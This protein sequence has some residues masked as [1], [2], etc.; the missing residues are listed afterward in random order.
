MLESTP[1]VESARVNYANAEAWVAYDPQKTTPDQLRK[2]VQQ[3]GY[4]L[5]IS[6]ENAWDEQ[7]AIQATELKAAQ[8]RLIWSA[9]FTLPVF[10]IGMFFMHWEIGPWVSLAF[11]LPI[12][13]YFG[14]HFFTRAWK[15]ARHRQASMD[16]LVAVST[17]IA[18]LFS[19]FNTLFP[20]WWAAQGL[21]AHV[22]YEAVA[23]IITFIL[24]GKW[25][26][27]RAKGS[28]S[29][30]LKGLMDLQPTMVTVVDGEEE[31]TVE[32]S[33]VSVG[34]LIRVKPGQKV[35]VDGVVTEG[36]SYMEESTITGESLPAQKQVG[37]RVFAGTLNQQG[38]LLFRADKVG[39]DTVLSQI[40][41]RVRE[42]QGSQ[43]PVQR[44]VD[45]IASIFVPVVLALAVLTFILWMAFGGEQ[46][47]TYALLNSISVLVIACP[48][49]LGLATPTAI[50][51]GVGKGAA[52]N[53]L[54][55]DAKSLELARQV[56]AVVLDKTGTLTEG[57]PKV[58]ATYPEWTAWG[59]KDQ[60]AVLALEK[61][62]EHPLA[63]A[64]A[65]FAQ[66]ALATQVAEFTNIPGAGVSGKLGKTT[67]RV[68]R[69]DWLESL[70]VKK[71]EN[72]P[73]LMAD[74][75]AEAHTVIGVAKDEE[76]VG[77]LA[78]SD[79]LKPS[80]KDAVKALQ[81]QGR[82]VYLL[83]G[84]QSAAAA[85]VGYAVGISPDRVRARQLPANKSAFVKKL[86]EE[87]NTVAMVGDGVND[88]E[89][90]AVA[91]VSMAMGQGAD[92]AMDVASI[93][94]MTSD[95]RSIA[96]AL[97]LSEKTV[98]GIRQNLFWAF[99]YN[100]VGIPIAAGILYP[101]TGFL[102]NPMIA[103]AAMAFSSV[104]VVLNSLRLRGIK[105]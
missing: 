21:E 36:E 31:R 85:A 2:S 68:G 15:Q 72:M 34:M 78:L 44:L 35:A 55:R 38:S 64:V 63:K 52:N 51:V 19:L 47:F 48:C 16:T 94:L 99:I 86:Q 7:A 10:T 54:I 71:A 24:L 88:A 67:Y 27:E 59:K 90:L 100:V 79:S 13:F 45:R 14:R 6:E 42:A 11:T 98:A 53:L 29:A 76:M 87:G 91:D 89:A 43:A 4:D 70:G 37:D 105:L 61:A 26:E 104:S 40:I 50:M 25:L 92:V 3:V 75:E 56:T 49:A 102:L 66:G 101:F 1:G 60:A 84:D 58:Q 81:N 73:G 23:V 69:I 57:Q 95:P 12:L 97:R 33:Q 83:T 8:S 32:A 30:A 39:K 22:Y 96:Q 77:L 82:K 28:T 74:W 18:F 93:T 103:G 17:G 9:V 80:A 5:L 65:T 62:S 46:A 20:Q 41:A